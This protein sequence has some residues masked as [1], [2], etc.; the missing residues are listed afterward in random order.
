MRAHDLFTGVTE[1]KL[2]ILD[3]LVSV[4]GSNLITSTAHRR[5]LAAKGRTKGLRVLYIDLDLRLN[6]VRGLLRF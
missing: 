6:K 2:G 1:G 3:H 5:S 4:S